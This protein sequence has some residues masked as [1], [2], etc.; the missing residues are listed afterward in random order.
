MINPGREAQGKHGT[1]ETSNTQAW[2]EETMPE[3]LQTTQE[4]KADGEARD[5]NN[6]DFI[7][8][9]TPTMDKSDIHAVNTV[10][11]MT[12]EE[13]KEPGQPPTCDSH[14]TIRKCFTDTPIT[15]RS[16]EGAN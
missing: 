6:N 12:L 7:K 14:W 3:E 10:P 2:M 16:F 1:K 5:D 9:V 4:N 8:D 13:D 11:G 15:H